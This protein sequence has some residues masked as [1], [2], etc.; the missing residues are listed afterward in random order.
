VVERLSAA[1]D[2]YVARLTRAELPE[3][4][5]QVLF[6]VPQATQ[7][8]RELVEWS[9][10]VQAAPFDVDP[11]LRREIVTLQ[12]EVTRLVGQSDP[13]RLGC[14]LEDAT[15]QLSR[16]E[17]RVR[18]LERVLFSGAVPAEAAHACS[19]RLH[20]VGRIGMLAVESGHGLAGV[21]ALC[22]SVRRER[23]PSFDE[24]EPVPEPEEQPQQQPLPQQ[25]SRKAYADG[26]FENVA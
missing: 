20:A 19:E 25:G 9:N 3:H 5:A 24:P 17:A 26:N 16:V 15:A 12:H 7:G 21:F 14:S 23:Q 22:S 13:R 1:V 18:E 6:E 11:R 10:L 2:E 8:Y 4:V